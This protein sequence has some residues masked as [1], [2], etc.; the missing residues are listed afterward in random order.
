VIL[1]RGIRGWSGA[2]ENELSL[3]KSCSK[4]FVF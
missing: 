4:V 3:S 1:R 2:T